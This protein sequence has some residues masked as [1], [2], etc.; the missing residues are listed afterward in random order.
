ML[1]IVITVVAGVIA[2]IPVVATSLS[3][4]MPWWLDERRNRLLGNLQLVCPHIRP[5]SLSET[6]TGGWSYSSSYKDDGGKCSICFLSSEKIADEYQPR[7]KFG[8]LSKKVEQAEK[9]HIKL[10]KMGHRLE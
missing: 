1:G 5:G 7:H 4:L 2:A 10:R 9:L 8:D 3:K 6:K